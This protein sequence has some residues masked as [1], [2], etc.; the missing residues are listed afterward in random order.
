MLY[1]I[2]ERRDWNKEGGR[3]SSIHTHSQIHKGSVCRL[4]LVRYKDTHGVR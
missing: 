4:S 3:S 1:D 2:E